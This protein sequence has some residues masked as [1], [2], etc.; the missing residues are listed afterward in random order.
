VISHLTQTTS[1]SELKEMLTIFGFYGR[2]IFKDVIWAYIAPLSIFMNF[3]D[4]LC[5]IINIFL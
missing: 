4:Y 1:G 5:I 3:L 2:N